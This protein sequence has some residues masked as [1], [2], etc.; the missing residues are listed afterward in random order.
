SHMTPRQV[1]RAAERK[2]R[3]QE[4][5]AA[6]GSVIAP[7]D[8]ASSQIHEQPIEP[9]GSPTQSPERSDGSEPTPISPSQLA[10]NR[11]NSQLSSGPKSP[12]GKA[13]SSL[14]AVKTALTG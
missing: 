2:A 8:A 3:K 7:E 5:K 6:V 12:E 14:N 9:P 11:A 13:K 4:R 10:A 1:R